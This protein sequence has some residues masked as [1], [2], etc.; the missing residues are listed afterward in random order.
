[1]THTCKPALFVLI[2]LKSNTLFLC[3]SCHVQDEFDIVVDSNEGN[4][5]SESKGPPEEGIVD[6]INVEKTAAMGS[7]SEDENEVFE[8]VRVLKIFSEKS[9]PKSS[10]M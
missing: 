6:I 10:E 4:V 2:F 9:K 8:E 3:V 7:D 5:A 1:M